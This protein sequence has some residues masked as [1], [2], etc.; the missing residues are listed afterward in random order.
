MNNMNVA[1]PSVV[2]DILQTSNPTPRPVPI[3]QLLIENLHIASSR[4]KPH[5]IKT[6][7]LGFYQ[8]DRLLMRHLNDI[9]VG[10]RFAG[11][12]GAQRVDGGQAR[13]GAVGWETTDG[14]DGGGRWLVIEE[15]LGCDWHG[16][17]EM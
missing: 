16:G 2:M 11:D 15:S 9:L 13:D 6:M 10:F 3:P 17:C 4:H 12:L 8:H 7:N 1:A 14:G 5:I